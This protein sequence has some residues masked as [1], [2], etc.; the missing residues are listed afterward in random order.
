MYEGFTFMTIV[1]F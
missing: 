1:R